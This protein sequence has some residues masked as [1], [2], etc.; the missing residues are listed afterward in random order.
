[1][2]S[3]GWALNKTRKRLPLP[4][5]VSFPSVLLAC[6]CTGYCTVCTAYLC[7]LYYIDILSGSFVLQNSFAYSAAKGCILYEMCALLA[8]Q[9]LRNGTASGDHQ[10][11]KTWILNNNNDLIGSIYFTILYC[12]HATQKHWR[13]FLSELCKHLI[14]YIPTGSD[15]S[16][17]SSIWC[18]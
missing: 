14:V 17:A 4:L 7:V 3:M 12:L 16:K 13:W 2:W 18:S 9:I 6:L 1:M 5:P 8:T 15:V 11:S 10:G